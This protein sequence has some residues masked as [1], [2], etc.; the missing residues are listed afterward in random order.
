MLG[1]MM[2]LE[3]RIDPSRTD[4]MRKV[5]SIA[6]AIVIKRSQHKRAGAAPTSFVAWYP[7]ALYRPASSAPS[8]P[9]GANVAAFASAAVA[10]SQ[11]Y[12]PPDS[13]LRTRILR[14]PQVTPR[15]A[16]SL[17]GM[18][19]QPSPSKR[20]PRKRTPTKQ[21]KRARDSENE[22]DNV[23]DDDDNDDDEE[24]VSPTKK[25]R[26]NTSS[27]RRRSARRSIK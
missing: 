27:T 14:P 25:Q 26:K 2:T 13:S 12:Q 11:P 24:Y 23:R 10:E 5:C 1:S 22:D 17:Y 19:A 16:G 4:D 8:S 6:R 18:A 7:R 21:R 3:L 15:K 20:T 9:G